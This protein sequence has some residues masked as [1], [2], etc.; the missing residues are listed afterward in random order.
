MLGVLVKRSPSVI[1]LS[2]AD[3]LEY[4]RSWLQERLDMDDMGLS[5]LVKTW[6]AVLCLSVKDY[7]MKENLEPKLDWLQET[8]SLDT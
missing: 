5:K 3:N 8:L 2:I 1:G 6:P 4:K 7:R